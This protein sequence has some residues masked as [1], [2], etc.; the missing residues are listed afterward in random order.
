MAEVS[1]SGIDTAGEVL[2]WRPD[3]IS[4]SPFTLN[5]DT[6]GDAPEKNKEKAKQGIDGGCILELEVTRAIGMQ[7]DGRPPAL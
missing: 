2:H 5:V 4:A 1:S 7:R 3:A 6:L